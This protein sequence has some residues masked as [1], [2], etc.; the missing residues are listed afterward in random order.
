MGRN[1][2]RQPGA[3]ILKSGCTVIDQIDDGRAEKQARDTKRCAGA[4]MLI[5]FKDTIT[6][7]KDCHPK[8]AATGSQWYYKY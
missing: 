8:R 5:I 2:L 7:A 6:T 4:R 1:H 3:M